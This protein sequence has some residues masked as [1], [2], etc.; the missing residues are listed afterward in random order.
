MLGVK[1]N[2]NPATGHFAKEVRASLQKADT[3]SSKQTARRVDAARK[4][5]EI[6]WN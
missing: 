2:T 4:R 3:E 6:R 5:W 1:S